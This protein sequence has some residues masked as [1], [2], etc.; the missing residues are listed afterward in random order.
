MAP[1]VLGLIFDMPLSIGGANLPAQFRDP[2]SLSRAV[3][4]CPD[5]LV[6]DGIAAPQGEA[7]QLALVDTLKT[8]LP[9]MTLIFLNAAW[10]TPDHFDQFFEVKDGRMLQDATAQDPGENSSLSA[11]LARKVAALKQTDLFSGLAAKQLRLLAF[12]AR[13]FEA[14]AGTRVFGRGDDPIDGAYMVLEG[15]AYMQLSVPNSPPKHVATIGPGQLVGELGL[16]RNEPRALDM[17]AADDLKCLRIGA[18][19]FLAVVQSDAETAFKLLQ[20]VSGYAV[21]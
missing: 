7:A 14:P 2:L 8:L 18:E 16:I 3:I 20:V 15:T 9:R 12:G 19:A 1:D 5:V 6:L 21:K 4:K 10:D 17:I 11:D 13:W